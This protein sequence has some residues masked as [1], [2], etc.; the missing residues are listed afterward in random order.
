[1]SS[2]PKTGASLHK[3]RTRNLN[4]SEDKFILRLFVIIPS[5]IKENIY[6][7]MI[8]LNSNITLM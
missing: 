7:R 3:K 1:M 8:L 4:I 5:N 2:S 6:T